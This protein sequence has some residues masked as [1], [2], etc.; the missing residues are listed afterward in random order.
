MSSRGTWYCQ[1]IVDSTVKGNARCGV[2][3]QDLNLI[4]LERILGSRL[5]GHIRAKNSGVTYRRNFLVADGAGVISMAPGS[6]DLEERPRQ[7]VQ[8]RSLQDQMPACRAT[9]MQ[10][11]QA[12]TACPAQ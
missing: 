3:A 12:G 5:M 9:A 7:R 2:H 1:Q 6:L 11:R 8:S 10:P 4:R